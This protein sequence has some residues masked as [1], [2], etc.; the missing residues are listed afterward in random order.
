MGVVAPNHCKF[1]G[2][3]VN[4]FYPENAGFRNRK[5]AGTGKQNLLA[6]AGVAPAKRQVRRI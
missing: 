4:R 2:G 6:G 3:W 5:P 1:I